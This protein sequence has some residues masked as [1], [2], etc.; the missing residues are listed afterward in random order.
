VFGKT[1]PDALKK[2]N[3][4]ALISPDGFLSL[5]SS[6]P[7]LAV[8]HDLNFEHYPQDL[9]KTYIK[10]YR[11]FFPLF[12][13]KATRI[14]TVSEFSK[15]DIVGQYGVDPGIIDVAHNGVSEVYVPLSE[16]E[17]RAGAEGLDR[18]SAVFHLRW[19]DPSRARTSRGP[20]WPST[21]SPIAD[22]K[23]CMLVVGARMWWDK[24][25]K[26]A[27]ADVRHKDRVIF[28]GRQGREQLHKALG[29][30][31]ALLFTSYF[32]GFGIPVAEA[33]RCGVPVIAANA[34][35]LPEVAGDAAIYCDPFSVDDIA[36]CMAAD[37]GRAG[38]CAIIYQQRASNARNAT[39]GI[40]PR[41]S[42]GQ[43]RADDAWRGLNPTVMPAW[44]KRAVMRPVAA[45]WPDRC[46]P[47][48]VILPA[49]VRL[50]G[51][52]DSKKLA[53]Q[54]RERLRPLIERRA[55]AWCVA[56]AT[57]EEI[58]AI[59]ILRASFCAMHRAIS[60]LKQRPQHLLIDGDRFD[61]L[62]KTWTT[63]AVIEGD[64]RYRSIAAASVLAK[65]HRDAWM[66][67]RTW[68]IHSSD[69]S[70]TSAIRRRSIATPY[71]C[72]GSPPCTARASACSRW[73]CSRRKA[74][75][76]AGT[77]AER[78]SASIRTHSGLCMIRRSRAND[79]I[80][81]R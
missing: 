42:L 76:M 2:H 29:G 22:D 69:G 30:A 80:H 74:A 26:G 25:L 75:S 44:W 28:T 70:T 39:R 13:R 57:H 12:A 4:E 53:V 5:R 33:M 18:R 3:A 67:A 31:M 11:T 41:R 51:L 65:T 71:A 20:C 52:N 10:Y 72:T 61:P 55:L 60:G 46:S 36:R 49:H 17:K 50:P 1:L 77:S 48:R 66:R 9:P 63:P 54:D 35:S 45:A 34:T 68:S 23:V 7:Q 59:N 15:Q 24:R 16:D 19:L 62:S 47:R 58:D 21:A 81:G 40:G 27:W 8:I 14:V 56:M 78:A 38:V 79:R 64:G 37:A 43:L 6:I 73:T 32:E